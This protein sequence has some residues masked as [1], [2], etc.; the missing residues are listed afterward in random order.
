M[1]FSIIFWTILALP[2][3]DQLKVATGSYV[4]KSLDARPLPSELRLPTSPGY[5]RWFRLDKALLR[6]RPGGNFTV[7]Y[8][9]YEQHL[10]LGKKPSGAKLYSETQMGAYVVR[11]SSITLLPVKPKTGRKPPPTTGQITPRGIVL[12]YDLR[13][14]ESAK[15]HS[16]LLVLDPS[17]W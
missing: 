17:Y 2:A 1:L 8:T 11:G 13:E 4:A 7:S 3:T 10:P 15:R 14:G 12:P 5:Y 6:L 9:Y 16:L